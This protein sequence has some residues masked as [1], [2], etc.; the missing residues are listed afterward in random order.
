[1]ARTPHGRWTTLTFVAALRCD[2]IEAPCIFD[3]PINA[4]RLRAW[5]VQFLIPTLRPSD[6]VVADNLNRHE[7]RAVRRAIR[8]AG[9]RLLF[10]PPYSPDLNPIEQV[11]AK[12]KTLRRKAYARSIAAVWHHIR[13]PPRLLHRDKMRQL[14]S[15]RR[16]CSK[17]KR[18][19]L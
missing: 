7:G 2:R 5:V 3:G 15:T 8:G 17:L 12:L 6:V 13:R 11:F 4:R 1:V 16:L 19:L 10:L 14:P 9:C 18:S